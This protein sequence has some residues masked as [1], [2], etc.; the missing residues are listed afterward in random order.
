MTATHGASWLG[1]AAL[2]GSHAGP[3]IVP[4][5][6]I[7]SKGR[8][9]SF[10]ARRNDPID[11]SSERLLDAKYWRGIDGAAAD[12]TCAAARNGSNLPLCALD[13]SL[14]QR[15]RQQDRVHGLH[16]REARK[17]RSDLGASLLPA[18]CLHTVTAHSRNTMGPTSAQLERLIATRPCKSYDWQSPPATPSS[19]LRLLAVNLCLHSNSVSDLNL[20]AAAWRVSCRRRASTAAEVD[21]W[22]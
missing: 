18:C 8:T 5:A 20:G 12:R 21:L 10:F 3:T 1:S 16:Q 9:R 14:A 6:G 13:K 4:L 19:L 7:D 11:Q 22:Q 2:T 17:Q 15:E